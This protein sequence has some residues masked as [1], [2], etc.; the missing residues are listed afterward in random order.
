M[1]VLIDRYQMFVLLVG[2]SIHDKPLILLTH[3]IIIELKMFHRIKKMA[4]LITLLATSRNADNDI[5]TYL[6]DLFGLVQDLF[7][8]PIKLRK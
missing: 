3:L 7:I 6:L 1:L 4:P 2:Q 5:H 8:V